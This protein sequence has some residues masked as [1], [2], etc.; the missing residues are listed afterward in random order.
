MGTLNKEFNAGD[1]PLSL[2]DREKLITYLRDGYIQNPGSKT[3]PLDGSGN[4]VTPEGLV[5]AIDKMKNLEEVKPYLREALEERI[6]FRQKLA[7][8]QGVTIQEFLAK[9]EM[10]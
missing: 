4:V 8:E 5:D 7:F 6:I 3:E 1:H 10:T 2:E 9:N